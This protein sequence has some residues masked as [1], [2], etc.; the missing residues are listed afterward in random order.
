MLIGTRT[1]GKGTVQT[2]MPLSDGRALKLTTS[3]YYTPA[4]DSINGIGILPD[5]VLGNAGATPAAPDSMDRK[6]TLARR[7]APV[8]VALAA[9]RGGT[10]VRPFQN[11]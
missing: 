6:S 8:A 11:Y 3:R 7:D 9:L 5:R 1:Y 4:G 10:P 2:I